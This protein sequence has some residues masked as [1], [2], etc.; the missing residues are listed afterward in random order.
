MADQDRPVQAEHAHRVPQAWDKKSLT[1]LLG[2]AGPG[3]VGF[4][5]SG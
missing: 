1:G 4:A 3:P 5:E 2:Q